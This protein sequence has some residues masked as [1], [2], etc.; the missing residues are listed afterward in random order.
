MPLQQKPVVVVTGAS[1][2]IG[3]AATTVLLESFN[4]IVVSISRSRSPELLAL[5]KKYPETL[6]TLEAD[7]T[8]ERAVREAVGLVVKIYQRIDALV[9][10]A[11]V[12]QPFGRIED[13][14]T[15][16]DSWR[17]HFDLN[18]FSLLYTVQAA[19]PALRASTCGGRIVF[20]SSG[21]AVSGTPAMGVYNASK[22]VMNSF[23]RTLAREEPEIVAIALRPGMVD[24][25]MQKVIRTSGPTHLHEED[26]QKFVQAHSTGKLIKPEDV[27]HVIA[28]LSL[29]H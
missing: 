28:A 1:K 8:D 5:I 27:G 26:M 11:G 16:T 17:A 2:G 22:A 10:N 20:I 15:T 7:V 9:L 4:T 13:S 21:A 19:L 29:N 6:L 18:F 12:I 24:T 14:G 3:I 25:P 23:C